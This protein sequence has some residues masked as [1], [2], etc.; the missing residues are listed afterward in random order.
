M[1]NFDSE[2]F[3]ERVVEA[4]GF[5]SIG[6]IA[7]LMEVNHHTL[8]NWLKNKREIP[9][10]E[11]AKIA[12]L[13]NFSLNWILTGEGQKETAKTEKPQLFNVENFELFVRLI[14]R[15]EMN[16]QSAE[17]QKRTEGV[18]PEKRE[19]KPGRTRGKIGEEIRNSDQLKTKD[20]GKSRKAG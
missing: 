3:E 13:T 10:D 6:D 5:K 9:P 18:Q 7:D 16:K 20:N 1:A 8:R 15:E 19:I 12:V 4:F 14:V 2:N 11:L 17:P